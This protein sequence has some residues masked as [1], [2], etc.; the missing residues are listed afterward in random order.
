MLGLGFQFVLLQLIFILFICNGS[1]VGSDEVSDFNFNTS[2][3][4]GC[5]AYAFS[6]GA[7]AID[8][9]GL[10]DAYNC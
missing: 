3:A 5:Y 9:E 1:L 6:M 8:P 2:V 7:A 4:S 10:D